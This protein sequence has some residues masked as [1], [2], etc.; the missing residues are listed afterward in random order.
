MFDGFGIEVRRLNN[1]ELNLIVGIQKHAKN[2]IQFY[3]DKDHRV[4]LEKAFVDIRNGERVAFGAFTRK[5]EKNEFVGSAILKKA[6]R[7]T[8]AEIKNFIIDTDNFS[9]EVQDRC[10]RSL[11]TNIERFCSVRG[12]TVIEIEFPADLT[13]HISFFFNNGFRVS[14]ALQSRY[15]QGDWHYILEKKLEKI[16]SGDPF[17]FLTISRW[18]IYE[19][20]AF[21]RP[22][23]H[24]SRVVRPS[25]GAINN[26]FIFD[27]AINDRANSSNVQLKG[28]C[29]YDYNEEY[30]QK[31]DLKVLA[32]SSFD[33]KI[34]VTKDLKSTVLRFKN[35]FRV[36]D[37]TAISV[38]LGEKS[39]VNMIKIKPSEVAGLLLVVGSDFKQ[40]IIAQKTT[41]THV[42]GNGLGHILSL[43]PAVEEHG[44]LAVFASEKIELDGNTSYDVWGYSVILDVTLPTIESLKVAA[45]NNL[46]YTDVEAEYYLNDVFSANHNEDRRVSKIE[47]AKPVVLKNPIDARDSKIFSKDVMKY[48]ETYS[49]FG[50][51]SCY[52][53]SKSVANVFTKSEFSKIESLVS[54]SADLERS[55]YY[56][57]EKIDRLIFYLKES[58]SLTSE[59]PFLLPALKTDC[60]SL[61][62]D[63]SK[64]KAG[65]KVISG[66][67]GSLPE[68]YLNQLAGLITDFKEM[69]AEIPPSESLENSN[70]SAIAAKTGKVLETCYPFK[71]K[72]PNYDRL[73]KFFIDVLS[74]KSFFS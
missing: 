65:T 49:E 21:P 30:D 54:D 73:V 27:V 37:K 53:D 63:L 10:Q 32:D 19:H 6:T 70:L 17:D 68:F 66:D 11:L 60:D 43:S 46:L 36:I 38:I 7:Q 12:F 13:G 22:A 40:R 59:L 42:L 58:L 5:A 62:E 67:D 9:T 52:I 48:I 15:N 25:G 64:L 20:F 18:I 35:K 47:F 69:A 71:D 26:S 24:V 16:Y 23:N 31:S 55:K 8:H 44:T 74:P 33:L 3:N 50:V 61:I 29:L 51:S 41:Y 2:L 1:D 56:V 72:I 28:A 57:P 14:S 45:S 4:W 39:T 34:Y